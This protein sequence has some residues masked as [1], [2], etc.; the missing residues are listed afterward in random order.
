MSNQR[1]E[2]LW[3]ETGHEDFHYKY[4]T[5]RSLAE[6]LALELIRQDK[7]FHGV[8]QIRLQEAFPEDAKYPLHV[9][10]ETISL[11]ECT[12]DGLS[13]NL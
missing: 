13:P 8:A 1:Y 10:W 3:C 4:F 11:Y 5:R 6:Q 9:S 7:T 2:V 12:S